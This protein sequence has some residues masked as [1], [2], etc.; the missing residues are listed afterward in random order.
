M[1]TAAVLAMMICEEGSEEDQI[2]IVA[3]YSAAIDR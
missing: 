3:C 1:A 2:T